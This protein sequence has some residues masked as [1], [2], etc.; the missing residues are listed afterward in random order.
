M[1]VLAWLPI[2]LSLLAITSSL[3]LGIWAARDRTANFRI[4][5]EREIFTWAEKTLGLIP[6][7]KSGEAELVARARTA[8]AVQIDIGRLLFPNDRS[9]DFGKDKHPLNR[10]FR[11]KVLDPL[12]AMHEYR[13]P[14]GKTSDDRFDTYVKDFIFE[15]SQHFPPVKTNTSPEY[16]TQWHNKTR[17]PSKC[18]P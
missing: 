17:G 4:S 13:P 3:A 8:L 18:P 14:K 6:D 1:A 2:V 10:G 5:R 12:V 7:L 15:V 9:T 11:S 16:L